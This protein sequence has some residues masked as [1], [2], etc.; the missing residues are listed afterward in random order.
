METAR[1]NTILPTTRNAAMISG[2]LSSPFTLTSSGARIPCTLLEPAGKGTS[3]EGTAMVDRA[4]GDPTLQDRCRV[5]DHDA[6]AILEYL[7]PGR[8]HSF[9]GYRSLAQASASAT[10]T[11]PTPYLS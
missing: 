8:V 10:P 5:P 4:R 1:S 7:P 9:T 6:G 11:L 2:H 3:H